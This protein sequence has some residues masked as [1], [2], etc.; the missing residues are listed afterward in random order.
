MVS[1]TGADAA[2]VP[3]HLCLTVGSRPGFHAGSSPVPWP[4]EWAAS[5]PPAEPPSR[6][7]G[8]HARVAR[9]PSDGA[10][11]HRVPGGDGLE[12][13]ASRIALPERP[14]SSRR[15]PPT[16][17]GGFPWSLP[18]D[19]TAHRQHS[20]RSMTDSKREGPV[21]LGQ[22]ARPFRFRPAPSCVDESGR[23]GARRRGTGRIWTL[24]LS[25]AN[26]EGRQDDLHALPGPVCRLLKM[27]GQHGRRCPRSTGG[28]NLPEA[29]MA[30]NRGPNM[31]MFV[32]EVKDK[33]KARAFLNP[34]DVEKATREAGVS[35]FEWHFV[36]EVKVG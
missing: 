31:A 21:S 24:E 33:A 22:S 34:A 13:P 7:A 14:D 27:E 26:H 19:L 12:R 20:S 36:E 32:C 5:R 4:T 1:S 35:G 29:L 3:A 11:R 15:V 28:W 6:S 9:E 30:R 18:V 10:T 25:P 17:E 2:R 8:P 23:L 16:Q